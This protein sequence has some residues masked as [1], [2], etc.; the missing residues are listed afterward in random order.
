MPAPEISLVLTTCSRAPMLAMALESLLP[1]FAGFPLPTEFIL[2]DDGSTDSTPELLAALA[3]AAPIPVTVLNGPCAGVAA[4][5]NLAAAHASGT[6]LA[7]FDDDQIAQPGWLAA[8][9]RTALETGAAA[10]GG[11]LHLSL[12]PD[13]AL[14]SLGPRTRGILG[15]HLPLR[16]AGPYPAVVRPATNNVLIRRDVFQSLGGYD[17]RFTEGAE[18]AD[19]F[20]RLASVGQ[21]TVFEP[22]AQA[23]HLT[24]STRLEPRNLRWTSLRIGAGDARLQQRR[25]PFLGPMRLAVL[26][27]VVAIVRDLPAFALKHRRLDAQCSLWYTQGLLRALPAILRDRPSAFL[28]SLNFRTRNGERAE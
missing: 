9:H 1:Q 4:A 16:A 20:D 25:Q 8:L 19:L 5:R 10:V 6:F 28:R 18:D 12:P 17:I 15:E 13:V 22:A 7:S 11:A 23:L 27:L 21:T 3:R 14:D 26:R 2:V 24:P